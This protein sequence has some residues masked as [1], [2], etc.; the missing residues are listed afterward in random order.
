MTLME[1]VSALQERLAEAQRDRARA[2]GARDSALKAARDARA[3]LNQQFGVDSLDEAENLLTDLRSEL[4]RIVA[5]L[6][7]KLDQI[8]V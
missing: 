2:E 6:T 7:A 8:G 1:Q 3:E 5:E 4:E